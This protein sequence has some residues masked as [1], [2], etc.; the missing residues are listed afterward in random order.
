MCMMK[1]KKKYAHIKYDKERNKK[2]TPKRDE[3]TLLE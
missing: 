1:T 3:T 2:E